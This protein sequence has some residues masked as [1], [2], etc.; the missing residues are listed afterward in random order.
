[1]GCPLLLATSHEISHEISPRSIASV[2]G[3]LSFHYIPH[4]KSP[5]HSF[6]SVNSSPNI[7]SYIPW[8]IPIR[9]KSPKLFVH[10]QSHI[11]D[12]SVHFAAPQNPHGPVIWPTPFG[13]LDWKIGKIFTGSSHIES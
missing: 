10:E 6:I 2:V 4:Q 7:V 11:R 8:S 9:K 1:M 13:S 5:I 3:T 12:I